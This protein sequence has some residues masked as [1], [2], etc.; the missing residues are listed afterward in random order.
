[1]PCLPVA[2]SKKV[3]PNSAQFFAQLVHHRLGE[4]IAVRLGQLVR[5]N[6]VVDRREGAVRHRD[7]QAEIAQHAEGL[8]AGHLV[9]EMRADQQLRLATGQRADGV[10]VPDFF[11]QGFLGHGKMGESWGNWKQEEKPN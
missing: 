11:E 3:M 1:M 5:R 9:D 4:R 7:L 8:G 6:D 2:R 10:R